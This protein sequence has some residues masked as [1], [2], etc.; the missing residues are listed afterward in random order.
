MKLLIAFLMI[1]NMLFSSASMA[2]ARAGETAEPPPTGD[3]IARVGDQDITFNQLNTILNS[4]AVVGVS[5]P[6]LGTPERDTARITVLDKVISANLLYLDALRQGLDQDPDYQHELKNFSMG[7]LASTYRQQYMA[8][9]IS[10]S[11]EEVQAYYQENILQENELTEELRIQIESILRKQKLQARLEEQ[12]KLLREGLDVTIYQGNLKL[13]GDA[14]RADD[15]PL[16][17]VGGEVITW[18][19]MRSTLIAAAK[20]ATVRDPLGMESNARMSALQARIDR[21]IMAQKARAAGL[22]KEPVYLARLNE[23]RKT[24]LINLHR[25]KLAASMEPSEDVLKAYYEAN[26]DLIMLRE[27]R[28]LQEVVLETR[29]DAEAVKAKIEAGELTLF[30]AA[31]QY[32]IAPG[33]KQNLGEVGWVAQGRAQPALDAVIFALEPG[34]LGGPVE[35]TE[36]WHLLQVQDVSDAKYASFD[37]EVTRKHVRRKYIHEQL[38]NYVV[39]LRKNDF[40][41]T[42][43]EDRLVALAQQEADMVARLTEQAAQ[44]GSETEKRVEELQQ[45]LKP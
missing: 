7:T 12:R 30:Q 40:P 29:D 4:S 9:E 28:K 21:R 18:G 6:A 19:E 3:V 17:E 26:R 2:V 13:D 45:L 44:P 22:D 31:S 43:Y 36:G 15:A 23:F 14:E 35:S 20:G 25:M 11:E 34:E 8:G 32:S 5:I 38:N 10:V 27:N 37:D 16:A 39:G 33:A 24:R 1:F 42:V 41:I